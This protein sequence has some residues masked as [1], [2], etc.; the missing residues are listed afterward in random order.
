MLRCA[1]V[2]GLLSP[3]CRVIDLGICPTPLV[4][5]AVRELGAAAGICITGSHNESHWNALKFLG[6]D[7]TLLNSAKTEELLDIYHASAFSKAPRGETQKTVG[8]PE[9]RSRYVEYLLAQVDSEMI[10]EKEFRVAVDFC[11]GAAGDLARLLL[12]SLNCRLFPVNAEP[13]GIFPH[14]PAPSIAHM[15]DLIEAVARRGADVGAAVNVDGDRVAF[16]TQRG[17]PLSE[18]YT[19]PLCARSRLRHRLGPTATNLSTSRLVDVVAEES[20]Q[21]VLRT[22]VGEANVLDHALEMGAVLAGEGSGGVASLPGTMTFDSLLS[23]VMVLELMAATGSSLEDLVADFPSFVMRKGQV[24]CSPAAAYR[25]VESFRDLYADA[26]PDVSDGVRVEWEDAWLHV[27]VSSTEP[28]IRIIVESEE[29]AR[30]D[31]LYEQSLRHANSV[32]HK[33]GL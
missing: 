25:T 29:G 8:A 4:S 17:R 21:V 33:L 14:T 28:I 16:V 32:I 6:P 20:D 23:L 24:G 12:N 19:L 3:G 13:T 26:E 31:Q 30:T 22:P 27:R 9:I 10:R 11:S 1:T 2:A 5:F 18:E 15:A 7:G